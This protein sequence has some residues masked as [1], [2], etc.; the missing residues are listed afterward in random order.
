MDKKT[1]IETVIARYCDRQS[2]YSKKSP[3]RRCSDAMKD[4]RTL[5][6]DAFDEV[7]SVAE[8]C[9]FSTRKYAPGSFYTW[10]HLPSGEQV[11]GDPWPATRYPK[12][13][14]CFQ[15]LDTVKGGK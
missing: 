5:C 6:A 4:L 15:L 2:K 10:A 9:T 3:A 14:L 7:C 13:A 12:A 11:A 1:A 8:S